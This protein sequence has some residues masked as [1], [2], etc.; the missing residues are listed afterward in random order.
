MKAK[1]SLIA[2]FAL[3]GVASADPMLSD[4]DYR[5]P[6]ERH[7][8][9]SQGQALQM[10]YLDVTP[11]VSNG[12]TAVLLHGK[13]FCAATW[14]DTMQVLLDDGYRVIAP[15]Q[16]GFCKSS[17]PQ[18]YQYGLHT[19]A[20]NTHDLLEALDVERPVVIGHSMGG[21][22]AARYALQYPR[23]TG[24][25]V[26][27]NPIGLEDWRAKGVPNI[28]VDELYEGQLQTTRE[29][30]KDY[31]KS[32]YYVG[33]WQAR[34]DRWVDML[35]SMYE[36][37]GGRVT[38][39]HQALTADMVFNQPVVHEFPNIAVPTLLLIGEKDNTA[40][41][42]GRAS[43]DVKARLGDYAAL[44]QSTRQA[45]DGAVLVTFPNL[46]HS[47]HIEAPDAFMPKLLDGLDT[48]LKK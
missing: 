31:Q 42:K 2:S 30:I 26:L 17:K 4:F 22:L 28:T 14:E 40:L 5:W 32:T 13:N 16:I 20:A 12:R 7:T 41:G 3:A 45:I 46:G 43:E 48:I 36:G 25:L 10:A 21:M 9:T 23:E 34:Y 39:W 35:W 27:L 11:D 33:D 8:L 37:D 38:A 18:G 19:L 47:P 1:F 29:G 6:V 15:D 24:G 44:A